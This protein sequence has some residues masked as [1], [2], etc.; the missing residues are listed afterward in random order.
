MRGY[1]IKYQECKKKCK[2]VTYL[3]D[4][5]IRSHEDPHVMY[6]TDTGFLH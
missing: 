1:N 6:R 4:Q 5:F 3:K 2:Q